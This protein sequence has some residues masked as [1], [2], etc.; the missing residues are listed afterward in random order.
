MNPASA[1]AT[2]SGHPLGLPD[3]ELAVLFFVFACAAV[4]ICQRL[5]EQAA[6]VI[7]T[8]ARRAS[9]ARTALCVGSIVWALDAA[10]LFMYPELDLGE[11]RLAPAI[12]A[13]I[14][15]VVSGRWTIPA[16][17][18]T[19]SPLR[20]VLAG[21]GLAIGMLAGNALL[22]SAFGDIAL[23]M[24]WQA[25]VGALLLAT[26][27]AVVLA[28]RHRSAR[29]RKDPNAYSPF[30]WQEK[31]LGGLTVVPLHVCLANMFALAPIAPAHAGGFKLLL[32]LVLFGIVGTAY[33][34]QSLRIDA[35]EDR[36]MNLALMLQNSANARLGAGGGQRLA[37]IAERLPALLSPARMKL[38][39]QPIFKAGD[40]DAPVRLEALLRVHDPEL[41][42]VDPELFFLACERLGRT[43][44][45][46]RIVI[47]EALE[48]SAPWR[49]AALECSGISVN[50]TP[51][52][53][54]DDDFVEWLARQLHETA[55]PAGWLKLELTEHAMIRNADRLAHVMRELAALGVGVLMDDFGAGYSSL[56]MLGDLPIEGIKCDRT[57]VT[58]L[59]HD[60]RRQTLLR[61]ICAMARELDLKITIEGIETGSDFKIVRR[62]GTHDVQGY[63]LARPMA[64]D[65]VVRWLAARQAERYLDTSP[66]PTMR[67]P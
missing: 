40:L 8:E 5:V 10:G 2:V 29:L 50:I 38:H 41:Q 51:N 61:H 6:V 44:A 62:L 16:L 55:C 1:S 3:L 67:A 31:V 13:L 18:N 59:E 36:S 28:L 19:R 27:L 58:G 57:F 24:S 52:T 37:L 43:T 42:H 14:V 26:V 25:G 54:F 60:R 46:D 65:A 17:T 33:Q 22:F 49:A 20:V 32:A 39:F 9:F 64:A 30:S 45:A 4:H 63:Y 47:R 34:V 35:R 11:A 12:L 66:H 56:S 53:P 21:A 7:G 23:V 48:L 15:M